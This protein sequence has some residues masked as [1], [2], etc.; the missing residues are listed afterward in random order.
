M[1]FILYKGPKG[2]KLHISPSRSLVW[3]LAVM[4]G[5]YLAVGTGLFLNDRYR[6]GLSGISWSDR[7]Y[8]PNWHKYRAARGNAYIEKAEASLQNGQF[9]Q[10][11]H[12]LR[13]G[14]AR[15]P[16]HQHGRVLLGE[17]YA[18]TGRSDLAQAT[19]IGGLEY[20]E[21]DLAYL[22][23]TFRFL[24]SR[25][26]DLEVIEIAQRLLPALESS[27]E[28]AGLV[29][30]SLANALY[31]RGQF[32]QAEDVLR[33]HS[34]NSTL[35]GRL[36]SAKI[37]WDRGF[38]ELALA[39]IEALAKDFPASAQTY[40]TH[41]QWLIDRGQSDSARR[42][43]LLRRIRFPDQAQPRIDLLYAFD[44]AEDHAAVDLEAKSLFA[45]FGDEFPIILQIGDFAANTGRVDLAE[46]VLQHAQQ[47]G[48]P[49]EGPELMRVESLIV[50]GD[51]QNAL[52]AVREALE[53][54]PA[55]ERSLA[56]VF[57]GL[58]AICYFALGESEDANLFLNSYLGL[59]DT[60]AENLVAVA[61]RLLSVGAEREARRVLEHAVVND[62]LNQ[63]AL[64]RLI[65]FDLNKPDAPDLPAN[66]ERLLSM[67]RA[68][69]V[70]L[71]DAY[72]RLGED[73]FV[74]VEDR[75]KLLDRLLESLTG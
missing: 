3:L 20:H 26:A 33:A 10:A 39:L 68:S 74:F 49:T 15:A 34:L 18:A 25:R 36:L 29:A 37:E 38:P 40:R 24:F 51:Y 14:L 41:V 62:P 8:P 66:L 2:W 48:M 43:S 42:A 57:N 32:D 73:R 44:T 69:P 19:L 67:R 46:Q 30:G 31:F 6:Q 12:Q 27:H 58:R 60:R 13:A 45:D 47:S 72:N 61:D 21:T 28:A 53:Q 59:R 65:E 64:T 9:S 16:D 17:M 11:F 7:V 4:L 1:P 55:W 23:R 5:G 75:N 70:L 63:A 52:N 35:D 71:R 50:G 54:N 22:Q 56:P